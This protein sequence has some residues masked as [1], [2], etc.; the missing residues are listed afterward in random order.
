MDCLRWSRSYRCSFHLLSIVVRQDE[1]HHAL[2]RIR[3][4]A[5]EVL[6]L[7]VECPAARRQDPLHDLVR[8]QFLVRVYGRGEFIGRH[9]KVD[10]KPLAKPCQVPLLRG[11]IRWREIIDR[12]P[13]GMLDHLPDLAL[14]ILAAFQSEQA[15]VVDDLALLI[16]HVVVV[17]QP[18][19]GFEIVGLD[20]LLGAFDRTRDQPVRDHLP[21]L[22]TH[23]VH[24]GGYTLGA[25]EP[26]Q[27]VFER[28][29]ELAGP[30]IALA[31]GPATQLPVDAPGLVAF[32][33][34]DV[35][36]S[37]FDDVLFV[38]ALELL[39]ERRGGR[40]AEAPPDRGPSLESTA[41]SGVP[42]PRHRV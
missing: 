25:E 36:A 20:P 6:E 3:A 34:Q 17:Q 26:H 4:E 23:L 39:V 15:Q 19:A 9:E 38:P 12:R 37:D 27:V 33:T 21:L 29:E 7:A 14:E 31:S 24:G 18:L 5:P 35:Q 42:S 30:G 32:G 28:E 13:H 11:H 1:A 40:P 16:H 2:R 41:R 8:L 22:R 10:Q